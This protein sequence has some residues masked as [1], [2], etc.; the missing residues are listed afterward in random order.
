MDS[1]LTAH[2]NKEDEQFHAIKS[3]NTRWN[4]RE[5]KKFIYAHR[6]L[7]FVGGSSNFLTIY[8]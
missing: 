4:K 5:I 1:F 8:R 6:G 3:I 2:N 7:D